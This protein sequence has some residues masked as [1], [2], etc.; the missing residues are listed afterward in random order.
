MAG[1]DYKDNDPEE[2]GR[3]LYGW[4]IPMRGQLKDSSWESRWLQ[5]WLSDSKGKMIHSVPPAVS[6]YGLEAEAAW[7]RLTMENE[8]GETAFVDGNLDY[9]GPLTGRDDGNED[10]RAVAA[11]L[12]DQLVERDLTIVDLRDELSRAR[13]R[14]NSLRQMVDIMVE[15]RRTLQE[16]NRLLAEQAEQADPEVD[17]L[18]SELEVEKALLEEE[19]NSLS[20]S[21]LA[22]ADSLAESERLRRDLVR[23]LESLE[24]TTSFPE[25]DDTDSA[26][27]VVTLPVKSLAG[28]DV[29]FMT[30]VQKPL[31]IEK[32]VEE[33]IPTRVETYLPPAPKPR[34][35]RQ[36][37]PRKFR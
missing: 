31:V 34:K 19:F 15:E 26:E 14:I 8:S 24:Q 7:F 20:G 6:P 30:V 3:D 4:F 29:G 37:G 35:M 1:F 33:P 13:A 27:V 16:E 2:N 18:L 28:E 10:W 22:L 36:P 9:F 21:N 5:V 12:S 25:S 17:R 32:L 23:E 11:G